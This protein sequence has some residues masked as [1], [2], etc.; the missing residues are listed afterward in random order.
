MADITKNIYDSLLTTDGLSRPLP[1]SISD[2]LTLAHI[3]KVDEFLEIKN[4]SDS[5]NASP[6]S[7]SD[8]T[9]YKTLTQSIN[10][11]DNKDS[12]I[13]NNP[14]VSSGIIF[15]ENNSGIVSVN[16]KTSA[17]IMK[18][19]EVSVQENIVT[20]ISPLNDAV[21][22]HSDGIFFNATYKQNGVQ[23][24]FDGLRWWSNIDGIFGMDNYIFSYNLL[25]KGSHTI[26]IY[27]VNEKEMAYVH[28]TINDV[29]VP[30]RP[31]NLTTV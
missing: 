20:I 21:Y 15:S 3:P 22:R 10:T 26:R 17:S 19:T 28:I 7:T 27:D 23:V 11:S 2:S 30:T 16:I 4:L 18:I 6:M 5:L 24:P 12:T 9:L 14:S 25:S 8:L 29:S 1:Q 31:E 13:L